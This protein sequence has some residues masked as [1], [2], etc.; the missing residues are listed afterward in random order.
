[1]AT[2][3]LQSRGYLPVATAALCPSSVLDCDL[4][5][6]RAGRAYAELYRGST[7]PLEARDIESLKSD[8]VDHLYIRVEDANAYRD[9]LCQHVLHDK[10]V[11]PAARMQAL[12]E[13]TRVAFQDALASN[14][15]DRLVG[16]ASDYG[17]DLA[18]VVAER[19]IAFGELFTT[20]EHD[21]Y[22]FTHVCNVSV[23]CTMLAHKLGVCDAASLGEFAAAALL[24]DIGKR[25]IPSHVLNKPGKLTDDEWELIREHPA[26]GFREVAT[27]D[28]LTW[29]QLMVIYQHHER[30]D[31]SGYPCGIPAEEIHPWA[32]ICAV[33]DVF[34]ALTCHRPYRGPMSQKDVCDYLKKHSGAWFD[35]DAVACWTNH[36]RGTA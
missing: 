12:R 35:A 21:Y 9:Y 26:T 31:G 15:C 29:G 22:T 8:G 5:I 20:L 19:S 33:A 2:A 6:Q 32:K 4:F 7:Y 27:R 17:G 23:Y 1:M 24:H 11:P 16:V 3:S 30:I 18:T 25:H 10:C 36:V 28:D 14:D 13:V 34:D